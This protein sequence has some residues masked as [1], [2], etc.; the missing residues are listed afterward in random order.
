[1][2]DLFRLIRTRGLPF[3]VCRDDF[4]LFISDRNYGS[5]GYS[6]PT[7]WEHLEGRFT[8]SFLFEYAATLGLIDVAFVAPPDARTD[9]H[10]L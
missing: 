7:H 8:L 1:M 10:D 2:N 4:E 6:S 3:A 5:L 9:F